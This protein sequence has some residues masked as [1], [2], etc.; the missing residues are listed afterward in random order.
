MLRDHVAVAERLCFTNPMVL[1]RLP[2][3]LKVFGLITFPANYEHL[4]EPTRLSAV[5]RRKAMKPKDEDSHAP[6]AEMDMGECW[7]V[8]WGRKFDESPNRNKSGPVFVFV[9]SRTRL[10]RVLLFQEKSAERLVEGTDW[11]RNFVRRTTRNGLL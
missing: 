4:N 2:S 8:D 1:S 10:L 5:A 3:F 7:Y 6:L 11:L 9:E